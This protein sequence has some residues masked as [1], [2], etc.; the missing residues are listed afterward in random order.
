MIPHYRV[1]TG[2]YTSSSIGLPP[3]TITYHG[4]K[5]ETTG[6]HS[7]HSL[8]ISV[9]AEAHSD[10]WQTRRALSGPR[11]NPPTSGSREYRLSSHGSGGWNRPSSRVLVLWEDEPTQRTPLRGVRGQMWLCIPAHLSF[12]VTQAR[13][14]DYTNHAPKKKDQVNGI[15]WTIC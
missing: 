12:K 10:T 2:R 1:G 9:G 14:G 5:Q 8:P 4:C 13:L 6:R 15:F 7:L 3:I 11:V